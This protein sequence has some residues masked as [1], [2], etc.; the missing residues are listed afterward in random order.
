[1]SDRFVPVSIVV[2]V[3]I[4][5]ETFRRFQQYNE[6]LVSGSVEIGDDV[7]NS[8]VVF[9]T[10]IMRELRT[11]VC[12]VGDIAL[13]RFFEEIKLVDGGAIVVHVVKWRQ[14]IATLDNV[15]G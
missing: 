4:H 11:L 12:G 8:F 1:M 14:V 2:G 6:A 13:W 3:S 15:Y 10:W 5:D 7:F 9:G